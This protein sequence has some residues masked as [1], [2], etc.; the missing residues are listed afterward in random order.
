MVPERVCGE[1][2]AASPAWQW[3]VNQV[4]TVATQALQLWLSE[5]ERGARFVPV[6]A[7]SDGG[8]VS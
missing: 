7:R 5:D 4:G 6:S 2:L 1:L 3:M 8:A